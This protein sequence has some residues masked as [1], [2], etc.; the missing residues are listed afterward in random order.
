VLE[1]QV[2]SIS[3]DL[4]QGFEDDRLERAGAPFALALVALPR[5]A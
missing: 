1:V 3:A 4:L 2:D 5:R